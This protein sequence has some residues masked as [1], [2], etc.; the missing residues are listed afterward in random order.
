[1]A[2]VKDSWSKP[3][4]IPGLIGRKQVDQSIFTD[5]TV[6]PREFYE[7]F[8]EA[9]GG[10]SLPRGEKRDI[11]LLI[12]GNEYPAR[13][14]SRTEGPEQWRIMYRATN[15]IVTL[16]QERLRASYNYL[17]EYRSLTASPERQRL[18]VI[19]DAAHA[20]YLA[21]YSTG[22][23]LRYRVE[24]IT[25]AD[26]VWAELQAA[27]GEG[28]EVNTLSQ[29]AKN[30]LTITADSINVTARKEDPLPKE[31]FYSAWQKLIDQK[32][33]TE[34]TMEA[35]GKYRS[36][37]VLTILAQL[38]Y[39]EY[40]TAP[41]V[42]LFLKTYHYTEEQ[43]RGLLETSDQ[44]S[45]LYSGKP[46]NP[47]TAFFLTDLVR[48]EE[49]AVVYHGR[50]GE[51]LPS[52]AVHVLK[53][54]A[55]HPYPLF[56]FKA[57]YGRF[58]CFGRYQVGSFFTEEH[59]AFRMVA[60]GQQSD[61]RRTWIFQANPDKY[62][63]VAAVKSL[64]ELHWLVNRHVKEIK[65]GDTV[66]L[67]VSGDDAGIVAETTVLTDPGPAAVAEDELPYYVDGAKFEGDVLRVRLRVDRVLKR[68]ITR[69][70]LQEH[71]LLKDLSIIRAPFN[72]NYA[73][74]PEQAEALLELLAPDS[75][76]EPGYRYVRV[77][78]DDGSISLSGDM[79]IGWPELGDL[80]AYNTLADL[81]EAFRRTYGAQYRNR[82]DIIRRH[83]AELWTFRGLKFG[84]E[85][86]VTEGENKVL[87]AF[88]V[89]CDG[90]RWHEGHHTVELIECDPDRSRQM[91]RSRHWSDAAISEL[92]EAEFDALCRA[93]AP[94]LSLA[95]I[96]KAFGQSL[97]QSH[98]QFG[99]R[100]D[101]VVR[102]FVA[103]LAT[104]RMAIL[105]G[106]SGS[107][108]TQIALR[109]GQ[110][111]GADRYLVVPV[112]PDW[113][114]P[115]ALLG[116]EDAL[117]K[118]ADGRPCW[119]VP[120]AL[121]FMLRA[122]A[123]PYNPYL[124]V[125][126]EMNL[127]HVERYFAD[128]LSGME[129]GEPVLPNLTPDAGGKWQIKTGVA[130]SIPFPD[131]LFVVGTVNVDETTYMFS[132]KVLDRANTFEFRVATD[133]L[134]ADLRTPAP[135]PEGPVALTRGFLALA[136]DPEWHLTQAT[137]VDEALVAHLKRVHA[138]LSEGGFEFGHRVFR[139]AIRFATILMSAGQDTLDDAL[140]LQIFQ[141]V[142]PRL[143]GTRKRLE[144]T[145]CALA[146]FCYELDYQ[147]ESVM[148][149]S[150]PSQFNPLD[151]SLGK[152]K[153]HR[154]FDKIRRMTRS[155]R[156][157]QFTGFTEQ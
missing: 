40:I 57:E 6:I 72:T 4:G 35:P 19:T 68:R 83:V 66:Y 131:N 105:T 127:A 129:S 107:G 149:G 86:I 85:I 116:Y 117:Q 49:N 17:Q 34:Q 109:F 70:E 128:V 77:S 143:H 114:G 7:D 26:R 1:M 138:L 123:D 11:T 108:K 135:C 122:A 153:L 121:A 14:E 82:E 102:S 45:V 146:Q 9:N 59:P 44:G 42:T 100:H 81:S 58:V 91:P 112:R 47:R 148:D 115:E 157:N 64:R 53:G 92:T 39:V 126:D 52:E 22:T 134:V 150:A 88:S 120:E 145:L 73:V 96:A 133:D 151:K 38:P 15:G 79:T 28:L 63:V 78:K 24:I 104:K 29:G 137:P 125:L 25:S 32:Y 141:K 5:G 21:F 37:A 60:A 18:G 62:D 118:G 89:C 55:A 13:I 54:N 43:L 139:E 132:P 140:D 67:W 41:R 71:P 30:Q 97:A 69:R 103:S 3:D 87:G 155:L 144:P 8:V 154:S 56:G 23:P 46:N 36:T 106:L 20:E 156:A 111:F 119:Q 61:T 65:P 124:L 33:L 48:E 90:Y 80:R 99:A 31:W 136:S 74:A 93:D 84:S 110:W 12:E 51:K 101:E 27:I 50:T 95:D 152:A 113:T 75:M 94:R 76:E 98:I 10:Y 2:K 16:L 147:K 142:L 130:P